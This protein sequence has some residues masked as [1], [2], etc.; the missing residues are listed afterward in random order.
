MLQDALVAKPIEL[1]EILGSETNQDDGE[2]NEPVAQAPVE[3]VVPPEEEEIIEEAVA[4]PIIEAEEVELSET[5][6]P[7]EE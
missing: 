2:S 7:S 6:I 1:D 5:E 3:E 4:D